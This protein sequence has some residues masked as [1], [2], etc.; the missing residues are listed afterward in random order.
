MHIFNDYQ[1]LLERT[2][3]CSNSVL[4]EAHSNTLKDWH[5]R[6]ANAF[7]EEMAKTARQ[8]CQISCVNTSFVDCDFFNANSTFRSM[9][10]YGGK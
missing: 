6:A 4:S 3:Q 8:A 2:E 5:G 9:L 7:N 10:N 1:W